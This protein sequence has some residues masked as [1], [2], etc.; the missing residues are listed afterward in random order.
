MVS[1]LTQLNY[2]LA[3]GCASKESSAVDVAETLPVD[4]LT[5]ATPEGEAAH[6]IS[7][8]HST[9]AK[10]STYQNKGVAVEEPSKD[11][12]EEPKTTNQNPHESEEIKK[13]GDDFTESDAE[14][15]VLYVCSL[16]LKMYNHYT[17]FCYV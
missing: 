1:V 9:S 12:T 10:R 5:T 4:V 7:P 3:G 17:Y 6:V 2:L 14:D 16:S 8:E 13:K 11:H 15:G